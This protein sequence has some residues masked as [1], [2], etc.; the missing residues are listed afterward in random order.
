MSHIKRA[1]E[2]H[3]GSLAAYNAYCREIVRG[4]GH[5]VCPTGDFQET[6]T[7]EGVEEMERQI[8]T[9]PEWG[10]Y[11]ICETIK[12]MPGVY[13]DEVSGPGQIELMQALI[14]HHPFE[15]ARYRFCEMLKAPE[16]R[17]VDRATAWLAL[18]YLCNHPNV[19]A[20][21]E[22]PEV[23]AKFLEGELA[24]AQP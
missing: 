12:A 20:F 18:G 6:F 16:L 3:H 9:H 5:S 17:F 8:V 10:V 4:M 14:D 11:F 15:S 7:D 1:I 13:S 23:R 24:F 2:L 19:Q 22:K 21:L